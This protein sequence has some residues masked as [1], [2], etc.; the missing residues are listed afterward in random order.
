MWKV[1]MTPY[2]PETNGQCKRFNQTLISMIGTLETKDKH[3]WKDYL[4]MLMHAYNC[5]KNNTTYFS[6]YYLMYRQKPRLPIDF[7]F[8]PASP[9][10]EEHSYNKFMATLSGYLWWCYELAN[11]H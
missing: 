1:Q 9:Q 3:H 8:V 5:T 6:P 7:H 2:H 10:S 4:P 11:Q